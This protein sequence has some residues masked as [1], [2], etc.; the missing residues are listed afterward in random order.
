VDAGS[1]A[2]MLTVNGSGF[3]SNSVVYWNGAS[4]TTGHPAMNQL[5]A[6]VEAADVASAGNVT[7]V[8][9]TPTSTIYN[10]TGFVTS[11]SVTFTVNTP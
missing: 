9:K 1:A 2:F 4:R 6:N 5:T 7:V 8:V 11:N 10:Q 3:A